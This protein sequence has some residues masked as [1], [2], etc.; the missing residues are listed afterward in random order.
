MSD[1]VNKVVEIGSLLPN[2][3]A[4]IA[5]L[6]QGDVLLRINNKILDNKSFTQV[7]NIFSRDTIEDPVNGSEMLKLE[8]IQKNLYFRDF[9]EVR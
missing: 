4:F 3:P 2:Y 9:H 7:F 5:G 6:K 8:V 1:E